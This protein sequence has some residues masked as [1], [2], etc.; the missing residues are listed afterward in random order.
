MLAEQPWTGE[1]CNRLL[2][3]LR[4]SPATSLPLGTVCRLLETVH[5]LVEMAPVKWV[6][7]AME[8]LSNPL[9]RQVIQLRYLEERSIREIAR[10]LGIGI[11]YVYVLQHRALEHLRRMQ[12]ERLQALE[13]ATAHDQHP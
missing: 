4:D 6:K 11:N 7:Q 8:C 3:L 2:S 9:E 13:S 12:A 10:S 5:A 1:L